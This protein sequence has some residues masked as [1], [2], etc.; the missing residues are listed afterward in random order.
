METLNAQNY[1]ENKE[2]IDSVPLFSVLTP[3]QRDA[4]VGSLSTLVFRQNDV[5]V[6]EGDPGDLFYIIKEGTVT[7]SK[8]GQ[9]IREM[10]KGTFFGEQALLYNTERTATITAKTGVKCV[11][12]SRKKLNCALGKHL[13][14]IIYQNSKMIGFE[15]SRFLRQL[16]K[17]Q[18]YKLIE[19]MKVI[20]YES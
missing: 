17:A 6:K 20:S 1:K 18:K 5:I 14:Q 4:L 11:A 2:F 10:S 16:T 8:S 9:F 3:I 7:C 19:R 15:K 13:Q 12:I